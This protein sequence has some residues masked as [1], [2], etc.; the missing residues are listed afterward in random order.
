MSLV[1][2]ASALD[3]L[4]SNIIVVI[5]MTLA[6]I[7]LLTPHLWRRRHYLLMPSAIV[8]LSCGIYLAREILASQSPTIVAG[9]AAAQDLVSSN[10]LIGLVMILALLPLFVPR[11]WRTYHY[12][13]LPSAIVVLACGVFLARDFLIRLANETFLAAD[14]NYENESQPF[15][16][17]SLYIPFPCQVAVAAYGQEGDPA[18]G[19]CGLPIAERLREGALDFIE[20][21]GRDGAALLK[22]RLRDGDPL[23]SAPPLG[24]T[25]PVRNYMISAPF[26]ICVLVEVGES[27]QSDY[28][29][30]ITYERAPPPGTVWIRHVELRNYETGDI[31]DQFDGWLGA[32]PYGEGIRPAEGRRPGSTLS[33]LLERSSETSIPLH[34]ATSE[35][36]LQARAPDLTMIRAGISG[37]DPTYR[38]ETLWFACREDVRPALDAATIDALIAGGKGLLTEAP[39]FA[40]PED[41]SLFAAQD[42]VSD[43]QDY[44]LRLSPRLLASR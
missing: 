22:F 8:L 15:T 28:S 9:V 41:C 37:T 19:T 23:C 12:L 2:L 32:T 38:I 18:D 35:R 7:P 20:T 42:P 29:I 14:V 27:P 3:L 6:L 26:G 17:R 43:A 33:V 11:F 13:L 39:D 1:G 10:I 21:G 44:D 30:S 5:V 25:R 31:F 16:G 24:P 34:R 36:I 4:S 40:F